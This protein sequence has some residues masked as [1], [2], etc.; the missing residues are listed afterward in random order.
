[1]LQ[2][3]RVETVAPYFERWMRRF[4]SLAALG[5]AGTAEVLHAWEGLGYYA[6][7][8]RLLA[9]AR[10]AL[11]RHGGVP[12]STEA[13][14]ELPG[15][16]RYTAGAIASI[17]FGRPEPVLDGNVTRVLTRCFGLGGDPTREPLRSELWRLARR[18]VPADAP[19][20]FNQALMELGATLCTPRQPR[21]GECPLAR[22]CRARRQG[23]SES[24]PALPPRPRATAVT[25]GAGVVERGGRVLVVRLAD[26][27]PRW[28]GMWTFP[29]AEAP[30]GDAGSAARRAVRA[31]AD[32][33]TDAVERVAVVRHAVTRFSITLEAWRCRP[34]RGRA[35]PAGCAEI[36]WRHPDE[37][38]RLAM[39]K[40]HRRV[41]EWLACAKS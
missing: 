16:G 21:C 5:R 32:L 35:R 10:A 6:R 30:D 14:L 12:A 40:A 15:V 29:A 41:A 11:E 22:R 3:T 1:M 37:L 2:Q 34:A 20:D 36:A 24:L 33:R 4:P 38:S 27:A 9:G 18:L 17:A 25:V 13:L 19:G 23:L 39:P 26:T 7:A 28:A 31:A 8:R